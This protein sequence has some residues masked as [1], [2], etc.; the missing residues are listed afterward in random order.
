[1]DVW[2]V[3]GCCS[4]APVTAAEQAKTLPHSL[5]SAL[6]FFFFSAPFVAATSRAYASVMLE[7]DV[8]SSDVRIRHHI[9]ISRPMEGE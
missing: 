3:D 7:R 9:L 5:S 8:A 1:M 4:G 6:F 2:F